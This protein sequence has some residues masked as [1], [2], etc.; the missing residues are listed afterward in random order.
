MAY[1]QSSDPS[2][3]L[4][5][6]SRLGLQASFRPYAKLSGLLTETCRS[7]A[8]ALGSFAGLALI[9]SAIGIYGVMAYVVAGRSREIGIRVALGANRVQVTAVIL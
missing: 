7:S 2:S 4:L 8:L 1:L 5:V 6:K 9:L 3:F